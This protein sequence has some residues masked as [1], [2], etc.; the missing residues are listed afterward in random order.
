MRVILRE[1]A[2]AAA[3]VLEEECGARFGDEAELEAFVRHVTDTGACCP[4][5]RFCGALGFGGKFR[6]NGNNHDIPHVDCYP[7]HDT[8]ERRA[9]IAR[10]ND[11]L[12]W[13]FLGSP[14]VARAAA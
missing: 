1:Q 11:R 7:E 14:K 2:L 4:E 10:A 5:W 12:A 9:L 13:V 6:N 8:P 3:K